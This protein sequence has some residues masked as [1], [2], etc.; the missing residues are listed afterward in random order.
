IHKGDSGEGLMETLVIHPSGKFFT[1]AGRLRGGDWNIALFELQ[2]G[3]KI[4]S[5]NTKY[6]VTHACYNTDGSQL[7]LVGAQGQPK[8]KKDG[9]FPRFGRVDIF[10]LKIIT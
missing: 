9:E 1:M 4:A 8:T 7:I 6:R 5:L 3:N 10:D 2:S